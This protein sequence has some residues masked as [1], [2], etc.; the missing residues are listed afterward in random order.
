MQKLF[1]YSFLLYLKKFEERIDL[2]A[3][4][5]KYLGVSDNEGN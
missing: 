3:N 5:Y 2:P 1:S 4:F